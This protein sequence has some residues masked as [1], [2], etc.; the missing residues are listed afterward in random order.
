MI[1]RP[2]NVLLAF[3]SGWFLGWLTKPSGDTVQYGPPLCLAERTDAGEVY[4]SCMLVHGP[5]DP[6]ECEGLR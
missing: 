6:D 4:R 1:A 2:R 5:W 3:A